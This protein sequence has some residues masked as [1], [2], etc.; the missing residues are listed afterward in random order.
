VQF[1][2]TAN[3]TE[4]SE[5]ND[6]VLRPLP[7]PVLAKGVE[8]INIF[9]NHIVKTSSFVTLKVYCADFYSKL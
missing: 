2:L 9:H 5:V 1:P 7:C 8:D 4:S 3:Q 6:A